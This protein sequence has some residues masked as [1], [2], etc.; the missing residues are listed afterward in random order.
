MSKL[1]SETSRSAIPA[2]GFDLC[3]VSTNP[4]LVRLAANAAP[5]ALR[6]VRV[7][8]LREASLAVRSQTICCGLVLDLEV[9]A[10]ALR[11]VGQALQ[12]QWF[13]TPALVAGGSKADGVVSPARNVRG[14]CVFE[15]DGDEGVRE[16]IRSFAR[17]ALD[18]AVLS[19]AR[20]IG[21]GLDAGLSPGALETFA[22]WTLQVVDPEN[23]P[24]DLDVSPS[25][26][27][28]RIDE[29]TAAWRKPD[30]ESVAMHF[31]SLV[32]PRGPSPELIQAV[33]RAAIGRARGTQLL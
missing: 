20:K 32:R 3:V 17:T 19:A 25:E 15:T 8:D 31:L 26:M 28:R 11:A 24:A 5:H 2:L 9:G 16:R 6:V 27:R 4:K 1:E 12:M 7:G 22:L 21:W 13:D 10:A 30:L 18:E 29:I 33:E 23:P 14:R